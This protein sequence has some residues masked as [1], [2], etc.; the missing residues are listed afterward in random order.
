MH[1]LMINNT[2]GES[3]DIDENRKLEEV[4]GEMHLI[5]S[6]NKKHDFSVQVHD[7]IYKF[8]EAEAYIIKARNMG[9][10]GAIR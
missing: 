8:S 3:F 5:K 10:H 4:L 2:N 9:K 1:I 6:I 7:A